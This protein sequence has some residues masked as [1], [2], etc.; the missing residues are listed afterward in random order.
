LP[1][2]TRSSQ[3]PRSPTHPNYK[4]EEYQVSI[5]WFSVSAESLSD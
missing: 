1:S 2:A 5:S 3:R 4:E